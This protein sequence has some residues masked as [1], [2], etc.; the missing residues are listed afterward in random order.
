MRDDISS[1]CEHSWRPCKPQQVPLAIITLN[2]TYTHRLWAVEAD[3][4]VTHPDDEVAPW[5]QRAL[6][7]SRQLSLCA[8]VQ[9][10]PATNRNSN[11]KSS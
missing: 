9:Q 6:T 10:A 2:H 1:C 7:Q 8:V 4:V 3:C 11:S 5:V